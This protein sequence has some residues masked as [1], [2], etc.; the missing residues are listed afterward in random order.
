VSTALLAARHSI[1]MVSIGKKLNRQC[2]ASKSNKIT[3]LPT[4]FGLYPESFLAI[5]MVLCTAFYSALWSMQQ[6]L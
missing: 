2:G 5:L 6:A 1:S 3:Q 4:F